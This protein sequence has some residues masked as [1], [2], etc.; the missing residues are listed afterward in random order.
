MQGAFEGS[1]GEAHA[2]DSHRRRFRFDAPDGV[3]HPQERWLPCHRS[4]G[5]PRCLGEGTEWG[6]SPHRSRADRPEHAAH[7][8]H[9]PDQEAARGPAI[10]DHADPDP[11]H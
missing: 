8:R 6:F 11:D 7:E 10:Q 9:Q 4:R 2:Q 1:L 5:W 3:V